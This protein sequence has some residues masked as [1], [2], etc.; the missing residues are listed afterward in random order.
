MNSII[1]II[2]A[3]IAVAA[4]VEFLSRSGRASSTESG[5]VTTAAEA[6]PTQTGRYRVQEMLRKTESST[7]GE[8]SR[9]EQEP[10]EDEVLPDPF[11][12]NR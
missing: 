6:G 2:L 1:L 9:P 10:E 11:D 7:K 12:E 4:L 8:A 5:K 3:L